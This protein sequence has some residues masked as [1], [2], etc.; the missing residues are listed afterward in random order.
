ML[1]DVDVILS[2]LDD[3]IAKERKALDALLQR[4]RQPAA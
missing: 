3:G 4:I 1:Q 2:R